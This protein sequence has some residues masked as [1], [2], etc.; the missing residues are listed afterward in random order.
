MP[1]ASGTPE[2]SNSLELPGTP[3]AS[4]V[5]ISPGLSDRLTPKENIEANVQNVRPTKRARLIWAEDETE[6]SDSSLE[7]FNTKKPLPKICNDS[8]L[9]S[10]DDALF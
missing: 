6:D 2:A 5:S 8:G 9:N 4:T 7:I 1:Q 3:D 10:D